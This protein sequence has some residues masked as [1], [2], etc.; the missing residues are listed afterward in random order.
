MRNGDI[1]TVYTNVLLATSHKERSPVILAAAPL[2]INFI[3]DVRLSHGRL[4]PDELRR[5]VDDRRIIK[6]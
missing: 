5:Y 4:D 2:G 6:N 1:I 3:R